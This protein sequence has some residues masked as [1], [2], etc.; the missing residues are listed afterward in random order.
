MN[1]NVGKSD[2]FLRLILAA[3]AAVMA[4]TVLAGFCPLYRVVGANTCKVK[5]P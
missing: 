1:H 4:L 5:R 2:K 3:G